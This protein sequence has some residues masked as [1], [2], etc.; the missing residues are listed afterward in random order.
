MTTSSTL[1]DNI[2]AATDYLFTFART[3]DNHGSSHL[4]Y[5]LVKYFD[6]EKAA[7]SVTFPIIYNTGKCGE[8]TIDRYGKISTRVIKSA[9]EKQR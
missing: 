4:F 2:M 5:W 8:A 6:K 1:S 7:I 9:P 3:A